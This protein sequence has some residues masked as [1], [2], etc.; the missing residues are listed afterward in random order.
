[1]TL[2]G[3]PG[4]VLGTSAD[5]PVVA[6]VPGMKYATPHAVL[7]VCS[8]G[9][10]GGQRSGTRASAWAITACQMGAAPVMPVVP[11]IAES[12]ALPTP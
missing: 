3:L 1:M 12:F 2:S 10:C 11:C 7:D 8:P 5:S 9:G 4:A 6:S